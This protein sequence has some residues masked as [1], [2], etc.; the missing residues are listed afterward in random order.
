MLVLQHKPLDIKTILGE[1]KAIIKK[2]NYA[3]IWDLDGHCHSKKY[4][5]KKKNKNAF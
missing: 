1:S 3:F 5:G 4:M 2:W